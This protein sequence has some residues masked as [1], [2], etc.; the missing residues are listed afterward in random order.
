MI[1]YGVK[2]LSELYLSKCD[3]RDLFVPIGA[4]IIWCV[5]AITLYWPGYWIS[6]LVAGLVIILFQ[7]VEEYSSKEF[8]GLADKIIFPVVAFQFPVDVI[9]VFFIL[10]GVCAFVFAVIWRSVYGVI[11]FP[12]LPAIF[13]AQYLM[14]VL[15]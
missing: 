5:S 2:L 7:A 9:G 13:C 4:V 12:M 10:T 3:L 11:Y 15:T 1:F 8:L 6:G 14:L